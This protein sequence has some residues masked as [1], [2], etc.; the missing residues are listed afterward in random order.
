MSSESR[1][2]V[3]D[4]LDR[5]WTTRM[6][7]PDLAELGRSALGVARRVFALAPDRKAEF[8]D[9]TGSGDAG[10]RPVAD[11]VGRP[12]EVWQLGGDLPDLWPAELAAEHALLRRLRSGWATAVANLIADTADALGRPPGAVEGAVDERRSV[13][14]LLRYGARQG[15]LGFAPHTDFGIVTVF[16]AESVASLELQDAAAA[17]RGVGSAVAV[18]AGEMLSA[19]MDGRIR[20]G[21]HRVRATPAER[22]AVAVFVHPDEAYPLVVGEDGTPVTAREFFGWAMGRGS[23]RPAGGR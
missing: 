15:G 7:R 11:P 23:E 16:A 19:C 5:G 6:D 14:R 17:W 9:P 21:L 20:P 4:L 8:V 22:W 13:V 12:D 3:D 1:A 10:W 2:P 18:A